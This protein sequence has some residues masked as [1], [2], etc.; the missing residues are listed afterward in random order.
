MPKTPKQE[1]SAANKAMAKPKVKVVRKAKETDAAY[2]DRYMAA[3]YGRAVKVAKRND[4][5]TV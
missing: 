5:S 3:L 1:R 2:L 4:T